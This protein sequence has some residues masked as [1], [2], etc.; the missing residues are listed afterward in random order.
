LVPCPWLAEIRL[1]GGT[2][3]PKISNVYVGSESESVSGA[4]QVAMSSPRITYTPRP[5]ATPEAEL[6]ALANVYR[7]VLDCQAK[8][9]GGLATAPDDPKKECERRRLCET[10][11]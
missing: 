8:K 1:V 5:D 9:E 10:K 2:T 7:F 3:H 4:V 6:D 11:M